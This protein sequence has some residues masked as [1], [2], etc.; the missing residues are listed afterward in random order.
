IR[1][2]ALAFLLT[3]GCATQ[4]QTCVPSQNA[5]WMVNTLLNRVSALYNPGAAVVRPGDCQ[6]VGQ[7]PP[8]F[9]WPH[10]SG[11]AQYQVTLTYPDNH[12]KTLPAPRNW[13]NWDEVLPS[14]NYSWQVQAGAQSSNVR[15]FTVGADAV[16]FVVPGMASVINQL[17]A[18][19]HPRGLPDSAALATMTNQRG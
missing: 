4:A 5:D 16:P 18:K 10:L 3:A 19:P 1:A 17:L 11:T 12:T 8:D 6:L 15:R 9:S 2:V 13:I 14:G 7:S